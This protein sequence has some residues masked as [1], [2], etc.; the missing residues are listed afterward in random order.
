MRFYF[1]TFFYFLISCNTEAEAQSLSFE[2]QG[3]FFGDTASGVAYLY[4]PNEMNWNKDSCQVDR[5]R[6]KFSGKLAH[7]VFATIVYQNKEKEIFIEPTTIN[8]VT[9]SKD[10]EQIEILGSTSQQEFEMLSK[11]L[12]TINTRWKSVKDTLS[13]VNK[14]SNKEFQELRSWVLI[15]YFEEIREAY[16]NFFKMKPHSF[17]TAYFLSINIIEMNQGS[18]TTDT[19]DQY[20]RGFPPSLKNSLYGKRIQVELGKRMIAVPGTPSIEFNK[21]DVKGKPLSL[22]SFRGNYILLDFWGSWCVP[23]RKEN[24]HLKQLYYEYKD[25][26]FDIIGIAADD[27]TPDDWRKAIETDALP[28]HHVLQSDLGVLYN[29]L[30]YPTK[31]LINRH[32]I[33]IGRYGA[34]D[35][36]LDIKLKEVLNVF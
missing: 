5:S 17:V 16:L 28:W 10:F 18:L 13:A 7:P 1:L 36:E 19:L 6:F 22:S 29:I 15:P 34:D 21:T 25:R 4:Y 32:G 26:G 30:S 35:M 12:Q 2:I 24:P 31:I 11:S 20:Y 3:K 8:Y 9:K 23:C 27:R 14:R 33:I